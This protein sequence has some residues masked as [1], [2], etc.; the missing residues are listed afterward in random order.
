MLSFSFLVFATVASLPWLAQAEDV[1]DSGACKCI[2]VDYA[3]SGSYLIDSSVDGNFSF[4]SEFEGSCT[5]SAAIS[6]SL[7]D[8]DGNNT[9]KCS[10]ISPAPIGSLQIST[11]DI[12][13]SNLTT[14]VNGRSSCDGGDDDYTN[15]GDRNNVDC[16]SSNNN[17]NRDGNDQHD[18]IAA[19]HHHAMRHDC[20]KNDNDKGVSDNVSGSTCVVAAGA[21]G[22]WGP[23]GR[24]GPPGG[25]GGGRG[26]GGRGGPPAWVTSMWASAGNGGLPPWV[27]CAKTTGK[28]KRSAAA[29]AAWT[30][31][32]V[33][34]TYTA[35]ET[36]TVYLPALTVTRYANVG[37]EAIDTVV[38]TITPA[39]ST[40]CTGR[41][42]ASTRTL[43]A[44]AAGP[45][46]TR[47]DLTT[48]VSH[49]VETIFV[50]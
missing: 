25:W 16:A 28:P 37:V 34:T 8:S 11:C 15:G 36:S 43:T 14:G 4:A 47:I 9:Y 1:S 38:Q 27:S 26:G 22:N 44:T 30:S 7:R 10:S 19:H 17:F 49:I 32:Y 39:A 45:K 46:L 2:G 31:T 33:Q 20:D 18:G 5:D 6:T 41:T 40:V 42:T 3:D 35:T 21:A 23:G 12:P 13:Y 50:T 29:I 24:G 48:A